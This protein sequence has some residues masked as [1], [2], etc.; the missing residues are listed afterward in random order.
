MSADEQRVVVFDT[1]LRDG[2][3]TPGCALGPEAKVA[4]AEQL[5]RLGVNVIEA[6][7]PAA[8]PGEAAAVHAVAQAV[9]RIA[10]DHPVPAVAGL[11]RANRKD[12]QIVATAIAPAPAGRIHTFIATSDLH[13]ERKLRLT[14]AQ[15]LERAIDA[16]RFAR[17]FTDDVEFSAEDAS[18]SDRPYLLDVLRAVCDAGARTIN[19]P[20]TVGWAAPAEYGELIA[21]VCEV[22]KEYPGTIVSAHCH[23][24]LG[25]AVANTLAAVG[26]GARQVEVTINGLGERAGNAALEEVVMA[27]AMRGCFTGTTQLRTDELARTSRLVAALTGIAVAPNKAI[28]G[29]NAFAHESGIHQQGMLIDRRT[30]EIMSP[31]TVGVAGTTLP[32][33]KHSGKHALRERLAQIG[34]ML[35]DAQLDVANAEVKS[36]AEG[37]H[38][39]DD[40]MLT[41]IGQRTLSAAARPTARPARP[42]TLLE[43]VWDAHEVKPATAD[44]PAVLY[45][46]LHLVHEVT[47][48]QAFATLRARGVRVRCPE[49]TIATMD[50]ATSTADPG[51]GRAPGGQAPGGQASGDRGRRMLALCDDDARA[52]L[53]ALQRNTADAGIPLLALGD[54]RRGIVHVI[55]PE[56]GLTQ[57]GMTIVCGDS[58]TSTH[59]AFGALAFGIGTTQVSHVLATQSLLQTRPPVMRVA[60]SGALKPGVTAKDLALAL[61]AQ[62]GV[63]GGT[64][65]VLEYTGSAVRALGMEGRMTLCNMAIELGARAGMIA[66]DETTFEYLK[67]RPGA[68]VGAA[69]DDALARWRSLTSDDDAPYD[70]EATLDAD[71]VEPMITYGTNPGMAVPVTGMIPHPVSRDGD[72]TA[73]DAMARALDYMGLIADAPIAGTPID[74]VFVGSCTNSRIADLRDVARVLRGRKVANGVRMLVVP[75]SESVKRQAELEGL[76]EVITGAGA[77]WR[78]SGCSMCIAMNDDRL[79]PGQRAVSTSNRNFEGRQGRG[80]RTLLASPATAAAAAIAGAIVDPRPYLSELTV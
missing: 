79:E 14:R 64:G 80:G 69:W 19:V 53:D 20:D 17:E 8:S 10:L 15:G 56:L 21:A 16:V 38:M 77:E 55:G 54:P 62:I 4:I 26:A 70:K 5:V 41:S 60:I 36:V 33:G 46:D 44:T 40:A 30:Y 66:P 34:I 72:N 25:L 7:F 51:L 58:H 31:E 45:I 42:R 43:K 57:P 13:L 28:V 32:L 1:T 35:S 65:H 47:S 75:G 71:A 9:A 76:H 73:R 24:D 12:I 27:L 18:R 67:G 37:G 6:G 74:V 11:A 50:H 61:A 29:A 63:G 49:R 23:D 59:G 22:A 52:Q 39:I 78:E 68:P 48:A 3:Q 2:E